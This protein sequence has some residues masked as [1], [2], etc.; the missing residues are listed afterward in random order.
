MKQS[1]FSKLPNEEAVGH[2]MSIT[3]ANIPKM[4]ANQMSII[5]DDAV[6][7]SYIQLALLLLFFILVFRMV[8]VQL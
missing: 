6:L 4:L 7:F 8:D 3:Q 5:T 1:H 2:I